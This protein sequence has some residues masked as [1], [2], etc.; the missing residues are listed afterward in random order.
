MRFAKLIMLLAVAALTLMAMAASASATE[1]TSPFGTKLGI[2]TT[3]KAE[4]EGWV[5]FDGSI[6]VT[7]QK[8]SIEGEVTSAG[9]ASS[10]V[11]GNFTKLSFTECGNHTVTVVKGG[12]FE[13]HTEEANLNLRG[14]LTSSGAEITILTHSIFLGTRHCIITSGF[15][16]LG[17]ITFGGTATIDVSSFGLFEVETDSLCGAFPDLTGNYKIT[18]PDSLFVD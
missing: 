1:L 10:T 3:I 7:C 13:V 18:S 17:T 9:G 2:G 16:E 12:S 15:S 5:E 8:S 4:S 6:N 14:R 11:R